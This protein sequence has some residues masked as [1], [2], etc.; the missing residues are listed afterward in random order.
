MHEIIVVA[1][2]S[3]LIALSKIGAIEL[4]E[5]LYREIYITEEIAK[6]FGDGLPHWIIV[7][8]VKNTNNF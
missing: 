3:C 2:T 4:L 7:E 6:E 5:K 8:E 1:D